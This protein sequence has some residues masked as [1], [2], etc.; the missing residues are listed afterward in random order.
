[1]LSLLLSLYLVGFVVFFGL[2]LVVYS[3]LSNGA[4]DWKHW[5]HSFLVALVWPVHL[6]WLFYDRWG[7]K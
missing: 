6:I 3:V 7:F 2:S 1:M 4:M 5:G